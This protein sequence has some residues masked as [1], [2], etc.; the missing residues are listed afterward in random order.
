METKNGNE[1][2]LKELNCLNYDHIALV[3]P[4]A[5]GGGG[6]ALLWKKEV[7]ISILH[8]SDHFIDTEIKFKGEKFNAT[9]VYGAPEK[10]GRA[11]VWRTI[12]DR[13]ENRETPWF[14]TGDFN[15]IVDNSEKHGGPARAESSFVDFRSFMSECDLFDLRYS[16]NF[17]S[18]RGQRRN[19]LV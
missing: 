15:E 2:V 17:L 8:Q 11:E 12:K 3:P 1:F 10:E 7:E 14:L 9:F 18:W 13:A 5:Q 19:H 6:L 4:Y 16:G